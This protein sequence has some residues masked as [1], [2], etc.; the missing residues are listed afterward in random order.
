MA[1]MQQ[2]CRF[3]IVYFNEGDSLRTAEQVQFFGE[4]CRM[5]ESHIIVFEIRRGSGCDEV[6]DAATVCK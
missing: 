1:V 4:G 5:K 3:S 2:L 6:F